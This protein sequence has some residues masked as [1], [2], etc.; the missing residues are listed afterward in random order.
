HHYR[1]AIAESAGADSVSPFIHLFGFF[2]SAEH[3]VDHSQ[4]V[5]CHSDVSVV[6]SINTFVGV[7][8]AFADRKRFTATT[9]VIIDSSKIV[10]TVCSAYVN[11]SVDSLQDIDCSQT[12]HFGL[13][14]SS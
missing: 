14:V 6:W 10:Q 11:M 5:N 1:V 4:V 9:F 13:L 2:K 12:E 8:N 7:E 3:M